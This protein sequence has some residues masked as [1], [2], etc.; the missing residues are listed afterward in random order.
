[1]AAVRAVGGICHV[2]VA[3]RPYALKADAE[4]ST[5][6]V[7]KTPQVGQDGQVHGYTTAGRAPF[8]KGKFT[9]AAELT[10][11][12][13]QAIEDATVTLE[14]ATGVVVTLWGATVEG[15]I[16]IR[17]DTGEVDLNFVG[18]RAEEMRP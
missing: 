16:N 6:S 18:S 13:Y 11:A 8:I 2:R 7:V 12:D 4:Y 10:I 9:H 17:A 1:M 14:L 3:G 15:E 5:Q